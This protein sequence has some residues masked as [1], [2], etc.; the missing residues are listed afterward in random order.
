MLEK[1]TWNFIPAVKEYEQYRKEDVMHDHQVGGES[2][3]DINPKLSFNVVGIRA[4]PVSVADLK[5]K[6]WYVFCVLIKYIS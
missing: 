5:C 6:L 2:L 4:L 1:E 3:E